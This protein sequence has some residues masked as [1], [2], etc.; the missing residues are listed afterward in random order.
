MIILFSHF[1]ME[2][3][4]LFELKE[5]NITPFYRPYISIKSKFAI[6]FIK[7]EKAKTEKSG[8]VDRLKMAYI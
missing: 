2:V 8:A 1:R 3:F 7:Y 6:M 5:N 4:A